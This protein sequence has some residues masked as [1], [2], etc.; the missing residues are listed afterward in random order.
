M[1]LDEYSLQ[2]SR[3]RSASWTST[4]E[5]IIPKITI[6]SISIFIFGFII[7]SSVFNELQ[8]YELISIGLGVFKISSGLGV[9]ARSYSV[10]LSVEEIAK[11][12]YHTINYK[13]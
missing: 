7:V 8:I 13:D 10:V 12:I 6:E 1:V 5:S 3:W 11:K 2:S 4:A 9:A